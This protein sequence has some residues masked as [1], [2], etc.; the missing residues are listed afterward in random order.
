MQKRGNKKKKPTHIREA[1]NTALARFRSDADLELLKVFEIWGSAVG[2]VIAD[3][4]RPTAYKGSILMVDVISSA[5]I[6]QLHFLKKDLISK[7]NQALGS[8]KITD[9]KFKVGKV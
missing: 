8:E 5:W 6:H 3:N 7:V 1:L 4:S 9:I 2:R